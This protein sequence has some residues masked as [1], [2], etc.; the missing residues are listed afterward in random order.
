MYMSIYFRS[1]TSTNTDPY[2]SHYGQTYTQRQKR[3]MRHIL[4][5]VYHEQVYQHNKMLARATQQVQ[6]SVGV[7]RC[8]C[9]IDCIGVA[10]SLTAVVKA[11][12]AGVTSGH[13]ASVWIVHSLYFPHQWYV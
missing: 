5:S 2:V 4:I 9:A 10:F 3:F 8:N 7:L 12:G 6:P 11:C 1:F 13:S